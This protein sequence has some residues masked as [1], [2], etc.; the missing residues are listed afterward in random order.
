MTFN[1]LKREKTRLRVKAA[2]LP[3]S[4]NKILGT[5]IPVNN[6]PEGHLSCSMCQSPFFEA[7]V[8]LDKHR[9]EMGCC[10]CGHSYRLLFPLDAELKAFENSGRWTCP[11]HPDKGMVLIHNTD[12][13][14]VGC[15]LCWRQ[16]N[17]QL[18]KAT[19][20]VLA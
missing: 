15:Q 1:F 20:L 2:E 8:Y 17:I 19:G 7:W 16:V 10:K 3:L 18:K 5:G 6:L 9:L 14:S 12:V 4:V 13:V 11:Q